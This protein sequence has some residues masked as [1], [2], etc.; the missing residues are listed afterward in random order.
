MWITNSKG[1][2]NNPQ[3]KCK[4]IREVAAV[5]IQVRDDAGGQQGGSNGGRGENVWILVIFQKLSQWDFLMDWMWDKKKGPSQGWPRNVWLR[6]L[7]GRHCHLPRCVEYGIWGI[8]KGENQELIYLCT[9][10]SPWLH[11]APWWVPWLLP[12]ANWHV[13]ARRS[14]CSYSARLLLF[15]VHH[16]F[17]TPHCGPG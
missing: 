13:A 14:T 4:E 1:P 6:Y 8:S 2:T 9:A 17:L 11:G 10:V 7:G 3:G 16:P 12:L 5:V 15:Q